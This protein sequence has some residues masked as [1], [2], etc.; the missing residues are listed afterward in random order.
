VT[1]LNRSESKAAGGPFRPAA[2]AGHVPADGHGDGNAVL[3]A[4]AAAG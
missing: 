4:A 1:A 2:G 3:D